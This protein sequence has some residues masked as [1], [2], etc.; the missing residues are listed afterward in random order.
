MTETYWVYILECSN[1]ALYTGYTLD[2]Q[3]RYQMHLN[4]HGAKYTRSFKPLSIAQVWRINQDKPLAL[5]VEAY[6][7]SLPRSAKAR[8][9]I[10][11]LRL[12]DLFGCGAIT[13]EMPSFWSGRIIG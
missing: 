8:L 1:G 13:V 10:E 6:I 3:K 2:L 12:V 4:G 9:I 7:K 11:P 5:K